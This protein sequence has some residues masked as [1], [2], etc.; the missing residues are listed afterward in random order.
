MNYKIRKT[1]NSDEL[2]IKEMLY[3][4]MHVPAGSPALSKSIVD[5]PELSG[6]YKN[7]GKPDDTGLIAED[8]NNAPIAAIWLRLFNGSFKGYGFIDD[9][10]PELSMSV[11]PDYRGNGIG[12][13]LLNELLNNSLIKRY[14]AI[15]LSVDKTNRAVNLYYRFEFEVYAESDKS[16][17]MIRRLPKT[18]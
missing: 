6:Y 15:S 3:Y 9:R 7:W 8:V 13:R 5:F 16:F 18:H 17:T 14:N 10:I 4:A 1:D 11:I 2:K 12:S